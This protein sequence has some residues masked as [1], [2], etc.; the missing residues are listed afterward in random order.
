MF[1][2]KQFTDQTDL[3]KFYKLLMYRSRGE[4]LV[5]G[6]YDDMLFG[7]PVADVICLGL[8]V[9]LLFAIAVVWYVLLRPAY[10]PD[11]DRLIENI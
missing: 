10:H 5:E 7:M 3:I 6:G 11:E 8:L 1:D 9:V 4:L 2:Q